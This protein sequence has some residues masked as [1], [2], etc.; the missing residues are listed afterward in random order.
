MFLKSVGPRYNRVIWIRFAGELLTGTTTAMLAPFL[1]IY[2]Y[3]E[4][5]GAV[6]LPML[7]VGLQPLAD[8]VLTMIGGGITDR[9]GRKVIIMLGLFLQAV[10]ISGFIFADSVWM[11]AVLYV[12]NGMG[13][14]LYIPAQRAQ[15]AD[16]TADNMRSEVFAVLNTISSVGLAIGPLLG[17]LVYST[18]P[19][20]MFGLQG[21]TLFLYLLLVWRMMPETLPTPEVNLV[22]D[23]EK[24]KLK[25][26]FTKHSF[27]LGL[28]FFTLPISFFYAQTET[29][30]RIFLEEIFPNFMF[31]LSAMTTCKAVFA[32]VLEIP[33]VKLTDRLSMRHV[34]WMSYSLYLVAAIA[35]SLSS[36]FTLLVVAQLIL[37]I[38]ESIGLTHM[39]KFVSHI[40]PTQHRG[41]YFSLYGIHWDI[42]RTVGPYVGGLILLNFGG[43]KLF[44]LSGALLIIGGIF[45]YLHVRKYK[46][47][48]VEE[49]KI[50][51][52]TV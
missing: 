38:A 41:L 18:S 33:I 3:Q 23:S 52:R 37:V 48:P 5:D 29:N 44:L 34:I 16:S 26:V 14:S 39:L 20:V 51:Q 36:S 46:K 12:V 45:Q 1:I 2:L 49:Y 40:A 35:F 47:E 8:I 13:R 30:H 24:F 10:S 11:F 28:M 15:I 6:L 25:E 31:I 17:Y 50:V 9:L 19:E 7:I 43:D 32:I 21:L 4:L 27:V 22:K 42:S